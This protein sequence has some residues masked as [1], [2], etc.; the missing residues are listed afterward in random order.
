[1]HGVFLFEIQGKKYL[2]N[3]CNQNNGRKYLESI[4]SIA[5]VLNVEGSYNK[6]GCCSCLATV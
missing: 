1:M 6:N 4:K 2:V 3:I 5:K